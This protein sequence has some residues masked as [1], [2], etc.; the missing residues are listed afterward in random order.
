MLAGTGS[1]IVESVPDELITDQ[2]NKVKVGDV[3]QKL[4]GQFHFDYERLVNGGIN[5]ILDLL[6]IFACSEIYSTGNG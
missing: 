5:V 2:K 3:R 4:F 1:V 6:N